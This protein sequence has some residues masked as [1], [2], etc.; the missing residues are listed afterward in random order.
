MN[1]RRSKDPGEVFREL[2]TEWERGF[3]QLANSIMG[4]E[5]FSRSMNQVQDVQLAFRNA[6]REFMTDNLTNANMP[7]RDDVVD[8]AESVQELTRRMERIERLLEGMTSN[9]APTPPREGP[10]RTKRPPSE[11]GGAS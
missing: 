10:P 8:I 4:T 3:D 1:D 11:S 9:S 2:V 5:N 6:F 7:T